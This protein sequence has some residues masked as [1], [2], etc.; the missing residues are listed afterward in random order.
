MKIKKLLSV[1]VVLLMF[2]LTAVAET[3]YITTGENQTNETEFD[4]GKSFLGKDIISFNV[5]ISSAG[6]RNLSTQRCGVNQT[7]LVLCMYMDETTGTLIQDYSGMGNNGT[8]YGNDS[9]N[10]STG[11]FNT[12]LQFDGVD[13]YVNVGNDTSLN[14]KNITISIWF[15]KSSTG[16]FPHLVSKY[17]VYRI[18][19]R[20]ADNK[21]IMVRLNNN[22]VNDIFSSTTIENNKNYN[23][24]WTHQNTT[25]KTYLNGILEATKISVAL[26]DNTQDVRF[27]TTLGVGTYY[28]GST[29]EVLIYSRAWSPEEVRQN[30][31]TRAEQIRVKTNIGETF[32]S[33]WNGTQ[34]NPLQI[35][36][37]Q[38][39][40]VSGLVFD[41]PETI[42]QDGVT[43]YNY[44]TTTEFS[45]I[46]TIT[47]NGITKSFI[48]IT[49]LVEAI[50]GV[51]GEL[52]KNSNTLISFTI[53]MMT[54]SLITFIIFIILNNL[55]RVIK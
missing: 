42:I 40:I 25:S 33:T 4:L 51:L 32:S 9:V 52:I 18:N 6:T 36:Y 34:H 27:G 35:Q 54:L 50:V 7:G 30:Y 29:D 28:N 39:E 46:S 43:I 47:H 38:N 3:K 17:N 1:V 16:S 49:E 12:G 10:Y 21:K 11:K 5:N 45:A 15:N 20:D 26:I 13:D 41:I 37:T 23:F 53:V 8:W 55:M 22:A 31:L 19:I 48:Q 2:S 44:A 24:V 14:P